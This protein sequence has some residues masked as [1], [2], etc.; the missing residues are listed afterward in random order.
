MVDSLSTINNIDLN[1]AL[2]AQPI[3]MPNVQL[4]VLDV[5][6]EVPV[7]HPDMPAMPPNIWQPNFTSENHHITIHDSF[8]LH[9]STAVAVARGLLT[10]RDQILLTG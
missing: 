10:P 4:D 3:V 9:D 2:T 8:M 6:L 5:H 7:V 1:V